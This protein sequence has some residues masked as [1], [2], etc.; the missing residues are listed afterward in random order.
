MSGAAAGK[1]VSSPLSGSMQLAT[2]AAGD[3]APSTMDSVS[4][5]PSPTQAQLQSHPPPKSKRYTPPKADANTFATQQ[6]FLD[7]F[8]PMS[9]DEVDVDKRKCPICWKCFG[10]EPDPGF[11]NSELPVKLRCQHVFGH[12]CLADI[13]GVPASTNLK[14]QPLQYSSGKKGHLLGQ[15]LAAYH[16]M[17]GTK[18]RNDFET[19]EHMLNNPHREKGPHVFGVYWWPIFLQILHSHR[20]LSQITLMENAV[21]LDYEPLGAK[22][23]K[24]TQSDPAVMS[25]YLSAVSSSF[26]QTL[27]DASDGYDLQTASAVY[28]EEVTFL[29]GQ[30]PSAASPP[31]ALAPGWTSTEWMSLTQAEIEQ[32]GITQEEKTTWEEALAVETNLDKLKALQKQKEN[33]VESETAAAQKLKALKAQAA[34]EE[35]RKQEVERA[36]GMQFLLWDLRFECLSVTHSLSSSYGTSKTA[37]QGVSSSPSSRG[38]RSIH[39]L[40]LTE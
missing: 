1:A 31:P 37:H 8:Q 2:D 4:Q 12:K 5:T 19:F 32:S 33:A 6:A 35:A 17:H 29:G 24:H 9:L 34:L 38:L 21:V 7:S 14:L 27:L 23:H 30:A 40:S 16:A 26:E 13:F 28:P 36:Q 11:D 18:F 15:K 39:G 22:K 3:E 25:Q 20:G 10:E